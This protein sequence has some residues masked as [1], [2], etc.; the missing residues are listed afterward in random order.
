M[1]DWVPVEVEL[2]VEVLVEL[3]VPE[4][5]EEDFVSEELS[6]TRSYSTAM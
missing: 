4:L 5:V 2:W 1:A 3:V 6:E